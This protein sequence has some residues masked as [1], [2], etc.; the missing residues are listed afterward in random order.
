VGKRS[1]Q[2]PLTL[3][4][5]FLG[6]LLKKPARQ[7]EVV[8]GDSCKVDRPVYGGRKLS[9]R[10]NA[11]TITNPSDLQDA[12]KLLAE[13]KYKILSG[14]T[15]VVIQARMSNEPL[16]LLNIA[17][18]TELKEIFENENEIIIGGAASFSTILRH[19]SI[20]QYFPVLFQACSCIGSTQIRNRGTIGGNIVNAA[21]CG[22]SVPPLIL[23][24]AK[25]HLQ[26][27]DG[28]REIDVKD[29]I[30]KHY[31]TQI[32]PDEILVA[33]TI[34]KPK[35]VYYSSYFQLG[36]RNAMNITRL[37]ISAKVS[38]DQN[39]RVD[40]CCLVDGSMFSR[41]QRLTPVE[42]TLLGKLLNEDSIVAIEHP[43]AEMI[44]AE[45][46]TRWSAEYKKPVFINVCQDVLRD[47]KRQIS[48]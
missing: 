44:E 43:L 5:V 20:Q 36:R 45:I 19:K 21:P 47:I 31:R 25:V 28:H 41:S 14:G 1:Y 6:K 3:E 9:L 22:D 33:I 7:S 35:K 40:E 37:S 15:D 26:S 38:F 39:K 13:K 16:Q 24:D 23:Y 11:I 29:F 8:H 4:Q 30:I 12:L 34:P 48:R 10:L 17:N 46:G 2:I 27:K 18:L 32:Q 42:N